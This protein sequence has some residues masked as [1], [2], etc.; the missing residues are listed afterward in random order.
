M[1]HKLFT[2]LLLV[3]CLF[4]SSCKKETTTPPPATIDNH[5]TFMADQVEVIAK[6]KV[7]LQ[8][9]IFNAYYKQ[10]KSID[11]QRLVENGNPQRLVFNI[12]RI[13]LES[14]T[15]PITINYSD[16]FTKPTVS[17]TYVNAQDLPFGS[18]TA[19]PDD[20]SLTIN[21]YTNNI[22]NCSFSG[23]L[24][25]GVSTQPEVVL[26]DGKVNLELVEY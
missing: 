23:S 12:Q 10:G 20:F 13:D 22:I 21:S 14:T 1:I 8:D 16:D 19:N 25:S 15:F 4:S 3:G 17:A 9:P 2:F 5:I 7:I 6:F 24:F 11:M 18:N 26:T